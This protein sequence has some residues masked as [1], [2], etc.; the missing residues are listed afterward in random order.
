MWGRFHTEQAT[1]EAGVFLCFSVMHT[2]FWG[3]FFQAAE[4]HTGIS[5]STRVHQIKEEISK[6]DIKGI[7]GKKGKGKVM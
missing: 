4:R 7:G 1:P 3:I 5:V 2:A 6:G